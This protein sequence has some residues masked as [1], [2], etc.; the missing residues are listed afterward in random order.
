M[1]RL[2]LVLVVLCMTGCASLVPGTGQLTSAPRLT[3]GACPSGGLSH[4]VE[5]S[6]PGRPF[7]ALASRNGRWVFV[8]LMPPIAKRWS[9][10][11][12]GA[13]GVLRWTG[14][15]L[16]LKRVLPLPSLPTGL[17]L[18]RSDHL[19]V[20]ADGRYVE[21][22]DVSRLISGAANPLLGSIRDAKAPGSVYVAISRDDRTLFVSNE[23]VHSVTVIDLQRARR[24]GFHQD[25]I[26]GSIPTGIAP[27]G[28]ALSH[29]GRY[30]YITSELW[31]GRRGW[32]VNCHAP[33]GFGPAR[34]IPAGAVEVVNIARA[35]KRPM[36]SVVAATPAG[37]MPVRAVLSPGGARLYVSARGS[38]AL[39][40]FDTTR[41]VS[42]P[43]G[44]R[45]ATVPVGT[46]PVGVATVQ[47]GR[48]IVVA[49]SS[50]FG[51]RGGADLTVLDASKIGEGRAAEIGTISAG[52]FPRELHRLPGSQAL[53]L[54]DTNS[55]EVE[56]IPITCFAPRETST[57]RLQGSTK[58]GP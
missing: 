19:L 52:K 25:A 30:L 29:D 56:L 4:I 27:V 28:L 32:P 9:H 58:T 54:T 7:E 37:C 44:A 33:R 31:G 55:A 21:F 36:D 23:A 6:V 10:G 15:Q 39:L 35:R 47:H 5:T 41:L 51:G 2:A 40:V 48:R 34:P 14:T 3:A 11:N 12:G 20:V 18:S 45:V 49:N 8:S 24:T 38:N 43:A 50:R 57:V 1:H 26:V 46:A 16:V 17:A 13:I 22:A 42:D 53:L